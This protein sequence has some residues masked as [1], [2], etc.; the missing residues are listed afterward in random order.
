MRPAGPASQA[1]GAGGQQPGFPDVD[2][3]HLSEEERL[4]IESVMAKAQM[5]EMADSAKSPPGGARQ[6]PSN[7][8]SFCFASAS[9]SAIQLNSVGR[10]AVRAL[11]SVCP[12]PAFASRG[13]SDAFSIVNKAE[14]IARVTSVIERIASSRDSRLNK[15][16]GTR[17]N[18]ETSGCFVERTTAESILLVLPSVRREMTQPTRTD[19]PRRFRG[20]GIYTPR[21]SGDGQ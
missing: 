1:A 8:R 13:Q 15:E 4:L 14:R 19:G 7:L 17:R 20:G 21:C 9:A 6:V 11:V 10:A 2:M 3:S 18:R 12:A 5:E 16:R